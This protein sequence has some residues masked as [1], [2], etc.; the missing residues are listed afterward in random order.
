MQP[1]PALVHPPPPLSRSAA[2]ACILAIAGSVFLAYV[3]AMRAGTVRFDDT[4][5]I[6]NNSLLRSV[7]GLH[8]IWTS[9]STYP[10]GLPFYPVTFTSYWLECRLWGTNPTGYHLFSIGLHAVNAVLVWLLLRRLHLPGA[11]LAALLFAVHPVQVQSVAWLAERKNLL[12]ALF[13][14]LAALAWLRFARSGS[15]LVYAAALV[16]FL[17]SLLSKTVACTL[18][19]VLLLWIWWRRPPPVKKYILLVMPFLCMAIP[20]VAFT[21][22]RENTLLEGKTFASGLSPIERMLIVGRALWFYAGKLLLPINLVPVYPHWPVDAKAIAAY[23]FPLAALAA[24]DAA[25]RFRRRIGRAPLVAML[26]FVVNMAP[27]SGLVDFGY[28]GKSFVGDHYQ[29]VPSLAAFAGLASLGTMLAARAGRLGRSVPPILAVAVVTGLGTL[30]WRQCE[31]YRDA[32]TFWANVV[33]HNRSPTAMS[34]LGDA[35]LL[36]KDLTRAEELLREA[37]AQ[38]DS[39]STRF[40]LGCVLIER[41]QYAAAAEQFEQALRLNRAHDRIRGMNERILMNLGFCHQALGE[42]GR[43]ANAYRQ[44]LELDPSSAAARQGLL[45]SEDALRLQ[46][47]PALDG[48][49]PSTGPGETT[50][51]QH[52]PLPG[53]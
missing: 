28:M 21:I 46:K 7:Q 42:H 38:R 48:S 5:Y 12:S 49:P 33:A 30:T 39:A 14:F 15:R 16:M 53:R 24:L 36:K 35:Y 3:P 44:A 18:P 34:A 31:V 29:Y 20:L 19:V 45:F 27:T 26:F 6:Q 47:K 43:A 22:W 32:E 13:F 25:W 51:E 52:A 50:N 9:P 11:L 17:L 23:A 1:E 2:A 40:R 8:D 41:R 10:P 4:D 37:L